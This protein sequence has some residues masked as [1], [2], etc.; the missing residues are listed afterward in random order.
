[1]TSRP[2]GASRLVTL[3]TVALFINYVDRGNLATAAP[4]MQDQLRLSA[5]ELGVLLSAFYYGYVACMPA[6]GWLAGPMAQ[7]AS[8]LWAWRFG[9]SPPC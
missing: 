7:S 9:H 5:S 4:L 8:S 3:V 6:M 1:M 2:D